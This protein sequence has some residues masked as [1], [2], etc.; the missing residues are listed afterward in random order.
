MCPGPLQRRVRRRLRRRALRSH[1]DIAY[2]LFPSLLSRSTT[3][4][5]NPEATTI[6]TNGA[7]QSSLLP[8]SSSPISAA[9]QCRKLV[10]RQNTAVVHAHPAVTKLSAYDL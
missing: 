9:Y 2:L 4:P 5:T 7:S 6:V 3:D 10:A 1:C 8:N